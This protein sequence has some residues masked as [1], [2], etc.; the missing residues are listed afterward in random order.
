MQFEDRITIVR[1]DGVEHNAEVRSVDVETSSINVRIQYKDGETPDEFVNLF[2]EL[3]ADTPKE[4]I[5]FFE[6]R[7]S[8]TR[9]DGRVYETDFFVNC[10][11]ENTEKVERS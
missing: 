3:P 11:S 2:T 9:P 8:Y 6:R 7:Y 10:T 1:I 4:A 5:C